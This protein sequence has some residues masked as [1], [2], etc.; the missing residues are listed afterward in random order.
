MLL[1]YGHVIGICFPIYIGVYYCNN[2][3]VK[4]VSKKHILSVSLILIT[5]LLPITYATRYAGYLYH[6]TEGWPPPHGVAGDIMTVDK[7]ATEDYHYSQW[8]TVILSYRP[9]Y[10][11]QVGYRKANYTNY[12][13]QFYVEKYDEKGHFIMPYGSPTPGTHY[14]YWIS[15]NPTTGEWTAGVTN[16]F[17]H[18]FGVLNP[19]IARDYHALCE[20]KYYPLNLDGTHFRDLVYKLRYDWRLWDTYTVREDSPYDVIEI[21]S[22]EFEVRGGG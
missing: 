4:V 17:T 6:G 14:E 19:N 3:S 5:V 22:Y 8:V 12:E 10:W 9:L 15:K 16:V 2:Y 18:Y 1:G 13:L 7:S 21:H 20:V 11:I